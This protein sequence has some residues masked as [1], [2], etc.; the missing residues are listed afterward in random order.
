MNLDLQRFDLDLVEPL[1]TADRVIESRS[2]FLVRVRTENRRGL[3]EATPLPGWTESLEE[4]EQ[5]L[6]RAQD[7]L[8]LRGP[9]AT[10]EEIADVPAARHGLSL[11]LADVRARRLD[12]PLVRHLGGGSRARS[13]R[14]R[15]NATIGDG[16]VEATVEAAE[17]A[18]VD[19]FD[20]LKVKVGARDLE[21]DVE[22]IEA[23]RNAVGPDPELRADANEAWD[24]PTAET[25]LD[26]LAAHDVSYVEQP[27]SAGDLVGHAKLRGGPVGV[28]LDESV[29]VSDID[30]LLDVEAADVLVCKP[31]VLGGPDRAVATARRARRQGVRP[32]VSTTVDAVVGR[33]GALHVAG[34]LA[35][36]GPCGLAT[37]DRFATDL[38]PDPAPVLDGT[39]AIPRGAGTGLQLA[40][41]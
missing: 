37:G 41:D 15:V 19:G 22:R 25:A 38:G 34:A 30:R 10:L 9:E 8:S 29:A 12:V 4:C 14:L 2:G 28:A 39:I 18:I 21:D 20:C 3:G 11:A 13:R 31:M 27:L 7:L 6:D 5:A 35:P 36:I 26:R 24:R 17:A 32:V 16:S 40:E 23:V 33:L 1:R